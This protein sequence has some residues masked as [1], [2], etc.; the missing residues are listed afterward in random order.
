[1]GKIIKANQ[2]EPVLVA[3][4]I[5]KANQLEPV[6]VAV[7]MGKRRCLCRKWELQKVAEWR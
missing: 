4:V 6:L 5:I 7:V 3:V 1:L 2:L